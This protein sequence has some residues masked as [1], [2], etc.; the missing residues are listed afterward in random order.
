MEKVRE[1]LICA[2]CLEFLQDPKVLPCAHSFCQRCLRKIVSSQK[3]NQEDS[4][5]KSLSSSV[6]LEC[7][8]CRHVVQLEHGR[9]EID[10]RTNFNLQRLVEIV[11]DKEK[12]Q[13]LRV[14][15]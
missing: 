7:P 3:R 10:L 1:E 15:C 12:S 9:V 8:S 5:N 14:R 4:S 13:T 6:D 11:S 2:V